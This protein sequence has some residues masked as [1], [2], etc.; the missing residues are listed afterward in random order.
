MRTLSHFTIITLFLFLSIYSSAQDASTG[1][2]EIDQ[3]AHD[4]GLSIL[5]S[6]SLN[7][8]PQ[9]EK[10]CPLLVMEVTYTS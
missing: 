7:L 1:I 9:E 3:Q 6:T 4:L 2:A 8:G 10:P 5:K